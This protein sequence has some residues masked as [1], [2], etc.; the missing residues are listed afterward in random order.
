MHAEMCHLFDNFLC[1]TVR[2]RVSDRVRDSIR[3]SNV[4]IM[5]RR[6]SNVVIVYGVCLSMAFVVILKT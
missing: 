1:I 4:S 6:V 2:I 5:C 3:I